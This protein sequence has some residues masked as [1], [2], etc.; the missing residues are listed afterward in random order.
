V[1]VEVTDRYLLEL[2][3][4]RDGHVSFEG[5]LFDQNSTYLAQALRGEHGGLLFT[6]RAEVFM[7]VVRKEDGEPDK[8]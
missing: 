6:L 3:Y 2:L 4:F 1:E 7:Y 5:A 8:K